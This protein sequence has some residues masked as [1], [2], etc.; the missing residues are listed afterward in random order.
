MPAEVRTVTSAD[1]CL[2]LG[3]R[4]LGPLGLLEDPRIRHHFP[5]LVDAAADAGA[6][7]AELNNAFRPRI[8]RYDRYE[9]EQERLGVTASLQ[10]APSDATSFNLDALYAKFG[11]V[12]EGVPRGPTP[13]PGRYG[14]TARDLSP[15]HDGGVKRL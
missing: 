8:P 5:A 7:L 10:F 6:T 13:Y 9:H 12:Q 2:H 1:R 3:R 15:R 11:F 14:A 4:L